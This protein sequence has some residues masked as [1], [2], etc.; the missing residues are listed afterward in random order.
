MNEVDLI[1]LIT[2]IILLGL[3]IYFGIIKDGAKNNTCRGCSYNRR[4]DGAKLVKEYNKKY[5]EVSNESNIP[6]NE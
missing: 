5:K 2:V 1:V 6:K 3:V 4:A